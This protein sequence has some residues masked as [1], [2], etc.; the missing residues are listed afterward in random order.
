MIYY[1]KVSEILKQKT[2]AGLRPCLTQ[3]LVAFPFF[4]AKCKIVSKFFWS[5]KRLWHII[6]ANIPTCIALQKMK[7]ENLSSK[8]Y[9]Y[10]YY[11]LLLRISLLQRS[12][13]QFSLYQVGNSSEA[14]WII[15]LNTIR[16]RSHLKNE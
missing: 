15:S 8:N 16:N 1:W 9:K 7:I 5:C 14:C 12:C 3:Q 2:H 4:F 11:D 6:I 13:V 10:T